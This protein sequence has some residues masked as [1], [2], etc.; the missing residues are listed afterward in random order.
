[1]R[2]KIISSTSA[3]DVEFKTQEA[4]DDAAQRGEVLKEIRYSTAA[5]IITTESGAA[6]DDS[7]DER[8]AC[9]HNVLIIFANK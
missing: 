8:T 4:I 9:W 7:P 6:F 5:A 3:L 1:M 2:V